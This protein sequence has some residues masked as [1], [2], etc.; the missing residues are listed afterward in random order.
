MDPEIM[1]SIQPGPN[2]P[3]AD[4]Y[5][6]VNSLIN[7]LSAALAAEIAARG[8]RSQD[9]ICAAVCPHPRFKGP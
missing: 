8:F 1:A 9:G 3:Y 4:E 5:A 7:E 2:Q 6:R